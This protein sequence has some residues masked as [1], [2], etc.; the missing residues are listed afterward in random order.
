M[1]PW[2]MVI[3]HSYVSH[4]QRVM[5]LSLGKVNWTLCEHVGSWNSAHHWGIGWFLPSV[6]FYIANWKTQPFLI[7]KN[8]RTNWPWLPVRYVKSPEGSRLTMHSITCFFG[9]YLDIR[10]KPAEGH[11]QTF[12]VCYSHIMWYPSSIQTIVIT[13]YHYSNNILSL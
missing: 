10:I 3:F 13:S 8:Q 9:I 6:F 4:Y 1:F 7:G 12:I 11:H 5:Y 2:K